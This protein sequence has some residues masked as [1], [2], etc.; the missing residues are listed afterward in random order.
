MPRPTKGMDLCDHGQENELEAYEKVLCL[1][2]AR[3]IDIGSMIR[4]TAAPGDNIKL[5][6][7]LSLKPAR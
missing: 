4:S 6:I 1:V 5:A 7:S 3:K 2:S